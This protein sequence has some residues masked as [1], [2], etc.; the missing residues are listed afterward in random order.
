MG[1]RKKFSHS[2]YKENDHIA[3]LA[4]FYHLANH[5]AKWLSIN[6][7]DY[8]CDIVYKT[9][10]I[11]ADS[12]IMLLETEIKHTWPGGI[13]PYSTVNILERKEKYFLEGADIL[14][15]A[16]NLKDYLIIDAET[17]L[18]SDLVEVPNKYVAEMEWFYQV[19]ILKAQFYRFSAPIDPTRNVI[20]N[21]G[22]K[23]YYVYNNTVLSCDS[24]GES[25]K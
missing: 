17:V 18:S 2:L 10:T 12:P 1:M 23:A 22:N 11:D 5:D 24:C 20:C 4:G 3:K 15:L 9:D 6:P 14:L 25:L 7:N 13:F 16:K 21:C 19:P 8:K